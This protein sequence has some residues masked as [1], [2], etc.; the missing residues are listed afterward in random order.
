MEFLGVGPMELIFIILLALLIMGPRDMSK[1][2]LS[3]GRF[4][5]RIVTSE[6]WQNFRQAS[7]ELS[8][9]P[10]KLIR[11][12]GLEEE[13]KELN[14]GL[15]DIAKLSK[16]D[17]QSLDKDIGEIM[18]PEYSSWVTSPD[19]ESARQDR[20]NT[21]AAQPEAQPPKPT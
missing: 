6:A 15:Q 21:K 12:A 20:Q 14:A 3:I 17:V 1:A 11:E 4:L 2:G 5:R 16:I 10:N 9:L 7:K 13:A 8:Y 18:P 19:L